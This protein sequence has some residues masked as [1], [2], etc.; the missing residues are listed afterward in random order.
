MKSSDVVELF[1]LVDVGTSI[2]IVE[3]ATSSALSRKQLSKL[4]DHR[5]DDQKM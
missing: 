1:Q 2:E 5:R 4:Q 3:G